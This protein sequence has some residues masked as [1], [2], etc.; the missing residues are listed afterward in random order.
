MATE[1]PQPAPGCPNCERLQ[2]RVE[3]LEA[4]IAKLK[5]LIEG[6]RR[7]QKRQAAPFSTGE[8]KPNPKKPGRKP[9]DAYGVRAHR[10]P[11]THIDEVHEAK[12]PCSCP[13]CGG[14]IEFLETDQQFQEEVPRQPIRRQFNVAIG[15]CKRC[16][17]RVQGRHALQTSDALGAAASQLG[18]DAQALAVHLN[19]EVGATHGKISRLFSTVFGISITRGG[20]AQAILRAAERCGPAYAQIVQAVRSSRCVYPDET[21]WRVGGELQWLWA[22]VTDLATAYV[23]RDSRGY[24]VPEEILGPAY[25]GLM[26]HDGWSPYDSFT[27]A[28]HQQCLAHLLRRCEEILETAVA[29]AV[30]FPREVKALLKDGFALRDRRDEGTI[31]THGLAVATGRLETRLDHLVA[32]R[33]TDP[34]NERFA[35]HLRKHQNE[36]FTFLK[37]PGI[38]ATNWPAEQAIRPST[39][40]RKVWGGNRTKRGAEAQATLL[41]VLRTLW[42]RGSDAIDFIS[43]TL[44]APPG[45]TPRLFTVTAILAPD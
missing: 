23:I 12:L 18:P 10:N 9:G 8:L 1:L 37:H 41:S 36:I 13:D 21:G 35:K 24:D 6:L 20:V 15:R 2:R 19:K 34:T 22:F 27:L 44:R 43:R 17:R 32:R 42:Q 3:A 7:G 29:G 45:E 28:T 4:E 25:A 11:P 16:Q 5:A 31:S 39:V 14:E 33:R 30:Q 38:E 26:G 40:N